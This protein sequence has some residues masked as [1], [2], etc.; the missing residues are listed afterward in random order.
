MEIEPIQPFTNSGQA[1]QAYD[2]ESCFSPAFWHFMT[3][4]IS[5]HVAASKNIQFMELSCG[6]GH[7]IKGSETVKHTSLPTTGTEM[8]IYVEHLIKHV[9][10]LHAGIL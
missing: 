5:R 6:H 2:P 4:Q 10:F 9:I 7:I 1:A 3:R 8:Y